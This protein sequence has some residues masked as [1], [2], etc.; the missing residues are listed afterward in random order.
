MVFRGFFSRTNL[1]RRVKEG[2]LGL[3]HLFLRQMVNRFLF[4]RDVSDPFLRTV[5]QLRLGRRLPDYVVSTAECGGWL[6][7]YYKEIVFSVRFLMARFSR[8]YLS[9]VKRKELYFA[10]CD[11]VFPVPLYRSLYSGG[12]STDVLKRVKKM[13][14]QPGTKTFFFK[15]HSG[16]LPVK[17]FFGGEG[18]ICAVGF[19]LFNLQAARNNRPCFFTLL[20]GSLFLGRFTKDYEE[21]FPPRPVWNK[22]LK[23]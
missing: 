21:R 7:G 8:D 3:S 2:G 17:S 23:H 6:S 12:P 10:L 9:T 1:F 22:V 14:V 18:F 19:T 15:L 16:T 11:V 4:L 5:C 20:G 13:H